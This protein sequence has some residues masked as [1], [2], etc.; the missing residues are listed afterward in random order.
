[1]AGLF[2]AASLNPPLVFGSVARG[3]DDETGDLDLLVDFTDRHD[4]TDLLD[5]RER[6]GRLL[7]V[8][9]DLVDSR[10]GGRVVRQ[11]LD[12]AVPL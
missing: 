4:I 11:A 7:T 6:L 12:E 5:L 8:P 3:D 2:A 9:V 10:A 1:M